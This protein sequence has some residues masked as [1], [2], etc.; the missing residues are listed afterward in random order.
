MM[1]I[2]RSAFEFVDNV[3]MSTFHKYIGRYMIFDVEMILTR[4]A[5]LV[6]GRHQ[7]GLLI[8][9]TNTLCRVAAKNCIHVGGT[10]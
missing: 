9:S 6:A 10:E 3:V 8:E 2:R 1:S 4:T 5:N 7:I